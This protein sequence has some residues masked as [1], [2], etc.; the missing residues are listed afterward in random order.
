MSDEFCPRQLVFTIPGSPGVQVTATEDNG[1]ID[2]T[3]NVLT[4]GKNADLRGLFFDFN[5]LKLPGLSITS[6]DG[7]MTGDQIS[8]NNVID[9]GRGNNVQGLTKSKFDIGVAFGTP[10]AGHDIV[11]GA[12]FT[13][14]DS[15]H[16]LTLRPARPAPRRRPAPPRRR[17]R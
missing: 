4:P 3:L 10:G 8:A 7:T 14:T 13:L 16:D 17:C 12:S 6:N 1:A 11:S 5:E 9:L 2:F 15:A